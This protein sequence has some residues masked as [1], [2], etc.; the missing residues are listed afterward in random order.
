MNSYG[1]AFPSFGAL[2]G[3]TGNPV[4][5]SL[6]V[7]FFAEAFLSGFAADFDC[8]SGCTFCDKLAVGLF[9]VLLSDFCLVAEEIWQQ[10]QT[11]HFNFSSRGN[12]INRIYRK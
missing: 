3:T 8:F 2:G 9:S 10:Q 7:F 4:L 1:V 6:I 5:V 11:Y 12:C